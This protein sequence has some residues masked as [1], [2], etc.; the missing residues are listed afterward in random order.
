MKTLEKIF[1]STVDSPEQMRS[2]LRLIGPDQFRKS[3]RE[4]IDQAFARA[5]LAARGQAPGTVAFDPTTL[6][7]E[8]GLIGTGG[9][10]GAGLKEMLNEYRRS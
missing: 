1:K 8:L 3:A 5:Q 10:R 4:Y 7:Q 9:T 2:M 6:R